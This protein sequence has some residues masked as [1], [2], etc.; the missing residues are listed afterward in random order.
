M[1]G[2]PGN[3]VSAF[4]TFLC[5]VRRRWRGGRCA[6]KVTF[7]EHPVTLAE[8]FLI[9]DRSQFTRVIVDEPQVPPQAPQA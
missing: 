4:V 3:P 1:F 8:R 6:R 2:L 7:P 5:L 9:G